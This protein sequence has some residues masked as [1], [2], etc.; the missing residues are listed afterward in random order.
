VFFGLFATVKPQNLRLINR[1]SFSAPN[2]SQS[3]GAF[4]FWGVVLEIFTGGSEYA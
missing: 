1:I 2:A 3:C 4:L